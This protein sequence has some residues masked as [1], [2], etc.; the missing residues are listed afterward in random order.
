MS[1]EEGA[2]AH[3]APTA[4]AKSAPR[5]AVEPSL[6]VTGR[7]ERKAPEVLTMSVPEKAE[8]VI[9]KG[10]GKALSE[11]PGVCAMLE[12][13]KASD[14]VLQHMHSVAFGRKGP[15]VKV[16]A[17]LREFSGFAYGADAREAELAKRHAYL[18]KRTGDELK[19]ICAI[20]CLERGGKKEELAARLVAFFDKPTAKSGTVPAASAGGKRKRAATPNPKASPAP[21]AKAAQSAKEGKAAAGKKPAAKAPGQAKE[22]AGGVKKPPSAFELYLAARLPSLREKND[23]VSDAELQT[24]LK[25]KWKALPADKKSK[26]EEEHA[27]LQAK[28]EEEVAKAKAKAAKPAI[29]DEDDEEEEEGAGGDKQGEDEEDSEDEQGDD[30][31]DA[32]EAA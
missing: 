17:N 12:K 27:E 5:D 20:C 4:K 6:V 1:A 2:P 24:H 8:F 18:A 19:A 16:K 14:D 32:D 22:P 13:H 23:G 9:A 26:F 31:A 21:T 28:Y 15:R 10:K 25:D 29:V 3:E 7:R 30:G 11:L